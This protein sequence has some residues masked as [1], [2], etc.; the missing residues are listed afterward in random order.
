M[1]KNNNKGFTLIEVIVSLVIMSIVA[2]VASMGLIQGV[3]VYV[4][5]RLNSET[6]QRAEY[7]LN[8]MKLELMNMDS[9][10]AANNNSFTFT[11]NKSNRGSGTV[12]VISHTGTQINL[13]VGGTANP[14]LTG[15]S[16]SNPFFAYQN[17]AGGSWIVSQGF[18]KL[19]TITIQL[20]IPRPDG[21]EN[22]TFTTSVNP[23]NNGLANAPER[24]KNVQ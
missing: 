7:A 11:S 21:R 16:A 1:I 17:N 22:F 24:K 2:I 23:R 20:V 9:V 5:T 6:L 3:Q 10:T 13:S 4:T 18:E 8:R 15:L 14:L 19:H 12:Y